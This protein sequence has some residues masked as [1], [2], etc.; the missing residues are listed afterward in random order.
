MQPITYAR[1]A[2]RKARPRSRRGTGPNE[3]HLK[4]NSDITPHSDA[5]QFLDL[6]GGACA[7]HPIEVQRLRDEA[8]FR[9][10]PERALL[11]RLLA[12]ADLD[13]LDEIRCALADIPPGYEHAIVI[14]KDACGGCEGPIAVPTADVERLGAMSDRQILLRLGRGARDFYRFARDD[15]LVYSVAD[16]LSRRRNRR[17][18]WP[19]TLRNAPRKRA[20][21]IARLDLLRR[22][23]LGE[24][25]ATDIPP[26]ARPRSEALERALQEQ[27]ARR[28]EPLDRVMTRESHLRNPVTTFICQRLTRVLTP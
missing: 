22:S 6:T 20:E 25:S 4:C 26:P 28:V 14:G 12:V 11:V 3:S 10:H 13:G 8:W 7:A 18:N 24:G 19:P 27:I 1:N 17:P 2:Q 15:E 5:A 21:R 16:Q 23:L 9:A